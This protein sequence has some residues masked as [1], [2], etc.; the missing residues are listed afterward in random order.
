MTTTEPAWYRITEDEQKP[1]PRRT[2]IIEEVPDIEENF[3]GFLLEGLA[4][5]D[6]LAGIMSR[7]GH[8]RVSEYIRGHKVPS[9]LNTRVANFGEVTVGRLL[10]EEEGFTRPIEKLRYTFNSDLVCLSL[11]RYVLRWLDIKR[12]LSIAITYIGCNEDYIRYD[13]IPSFL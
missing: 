6:H 13:A 10:E 5:T 12:P 3:G 1:F 11:I 4:D 8:E 2:A 9:K 7:H